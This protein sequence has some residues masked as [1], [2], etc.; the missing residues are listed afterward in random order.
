MCVGIRG[1]CV[2]TVCVVIRRS[3]CVFVL[4]VVSMEQ[5]PP[6]VQLTA[7]VGEVVRG[8]L[9][10]GIGGEGYSAI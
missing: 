3:V 7:A 4:C 1:V 6:A 10:G 5:R 2:R 8:L 9:G